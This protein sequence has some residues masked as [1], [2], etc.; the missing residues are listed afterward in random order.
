MNHKHAN[1]KYNKLDYTFQ[2]KISGQIET[3]LDNTNDYFSVGIIPSD[4]ITI[5]AGQK[6]KRE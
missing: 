3:H 6:K 5:R 2:G 1:I 4:R